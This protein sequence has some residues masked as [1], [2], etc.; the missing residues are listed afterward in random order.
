MSNDKDSHSGQLAGTLFRA[1]MHK[2]A[3]PNLSGPWRQE[4][5][6]HAFDVKLMD[7]DDLPSGYTARV[8]VTVSHS[9]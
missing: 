3:D 5:G 6:Q 2:H 8:V 1:A 9:G 7:S 4:A